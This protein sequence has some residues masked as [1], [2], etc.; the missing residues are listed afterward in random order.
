MPKKRLKPS[1][2][3]YPAPVLLISSREESGKPHVATICWAGVLNS[4]PPLVGIAV[5]PSRRSNKLIKES[6]DF[7]INIPSR[8]WLKETDYCGFAST[9]DS[10]KFSSVGFTAV[11]A[12]QVK[13]PLIDECALNLECV[14]KQILPLGSHDLFIAEIVAVHA[15]E[16]I[17]ENGEISME[18]LDPFVYCSIVHE[19]RAVGAKLGAYG[20]STEEAAAR[21]ADAHRSPS[22][23]DAKRFVGTWRLASITG[24]R[25]TELRGNNP[26]GL[27]YYDEAGNMAVQIM[28]DRTRPPYSSTQPTPDEAQDALLGYTAY[29]GQYGVDEEKRTVTHRRTGNINPGGLGDF[30]RRYEFLSEDRIVLMPIESNAGLTWERIR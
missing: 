3:L 17:L 16:D 22:A 28:P 18:L 8:K 2:Y 20:F 12:G 21:P 19:Y 25:L 10:D 15:D 30:I 5:R 23:G 7:V 9:A 6:G 26:V 14:V 24:G 1:T 29:F 11:E 4:E 13:A 27:L